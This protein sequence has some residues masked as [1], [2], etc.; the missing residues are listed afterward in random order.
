MT[1]TTN[2]ST[3][4]VTWKYRVWE[5]NREQAACLSLSSSDAFL[6]FAASNISIWLC[7]TEGCLTY[8]CWAKAAGK[9]NWQQR[10]INTNKLKHH[11]L[12]SG[13]THTHTHKPRVICTRQ[14]SEQQPRPSFCLPVSVCVRPL[15]PTQQERESPVEENYTLPSVSVCVCVCVSA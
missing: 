3:R 8:S 15:H 10:E 1:V 11:H 12:T 2:T 5:V 6:T 4:A 7:A 9:K 13:H 14:Y